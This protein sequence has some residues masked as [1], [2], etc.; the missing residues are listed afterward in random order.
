MIRTIALASLL[1]LSVLPAEAASCA[2]VS[3]EALARDVAGHFIARRLGDLAA[4][5]PRTQ[6]RLLVEHSLSDEDSTPRRLPLRDVDRALD[7][8]RPASP[9]GRHLLGAM[10]CR[11]LV[12][13]FGPS[14]G[15][16]HNN[17]YL[18]ELRLARQAGCLT[19]VRLHVLDGD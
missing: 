4:R 19:V 7:A 10:T 8:G 15:I 11:G 16:L 3:S 1:M 14:E 17:L 13:S 12:C 18:K 2:H 5:L 6:V 9:P